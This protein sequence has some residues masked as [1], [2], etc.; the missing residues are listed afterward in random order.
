MK[1][2]IFILILLPVWAFSQQNSR[3]P[4]PDFEYYRKHN[5]RNVCMY[6]ESKE[7]WNKEKFNRPVKHQNKR[8]YKL[9]RTKQTHCKDK[10][11]VNRMKIRYHKNHWW[12]S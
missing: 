5:Y 7:T 8:D 10:V 12:P 11:M 9:L 6:S 2:L 4:K 1:T 3:L